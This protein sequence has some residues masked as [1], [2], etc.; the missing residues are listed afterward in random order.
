MLV[1]TKVDKTVLD[2]AK[3]LK[4]IISGTTGINH[5]DTSELKKRGIELL[6]LH[7]EHT[8]P[9]AEHAFALLLSIARNIYP[10]H[11]AILKGEWDRHRFIGRELKELTL[12]IIG[13]GKIGSEVA[14]L[15][16]GFG[17]KVCAYDPYISQQAM[18]DKGLTKN[19]FI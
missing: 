19:N 9:T 17:M 15:A 10:A 11:K 1:E 18:E 4:V 16:R 7:G 14:C 5:I 2:F 3:D 13:L 12:G 6:H 8:R